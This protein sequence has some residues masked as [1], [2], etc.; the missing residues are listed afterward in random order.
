VPVLHTYTD[1]LARALAALP[2][3]LRRPRRR[4]EAEA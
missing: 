2:G 1:D 3:R 4:P